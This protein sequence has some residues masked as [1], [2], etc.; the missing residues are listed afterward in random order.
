[1]SAQIEIFHVHL[2]HAQP[3]RV[4]ASDRELAVTVRPVH[5]RGVRD[6]VVQA[7]GGWDGL[8]VLFTPREQAIARARYQELKARLS[9]WSMWAWI[10]DP[11]PDGGDL[12]GVKRSAFSLA[13]QIGS[14][15]MGV[16][17]ILDEPSVGLAPT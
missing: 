7:T 1:M 5:C 15:L 10:P 8:W 9:S 11:G 3:V 4:G 6:V 16:L 12:S 17:Y 2:A 13:T 14:Q